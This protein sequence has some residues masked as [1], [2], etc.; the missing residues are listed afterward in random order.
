MIASVGADEG[1]VALEEGANEPGRLFL[2]EAVAGFDI[3]PLDVQ[4]EEA[5]IA[6]FAT[7]DEIC[8][9]MHTAAEFAL[10][11]EAMFFDSVMSGR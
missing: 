9:L 11:Y 10:I 2:S 1:G 7:G 4:K 3:P 6:R 5:F 8:R